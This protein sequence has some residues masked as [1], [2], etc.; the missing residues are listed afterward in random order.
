MLAGG[1]QPVPALLVLPLS[2]GKIPQ[3]TLNS[4]MRLMGKGVVS[5]FHSFAVSL[6]C[7][8]LGFFAVHFF[9]RKNNLL[10]LKD[11]GM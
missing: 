7:L 3:V 9:L 2:S 6:V 1:A 8:G 11:E 4:K 10:Y 5:F